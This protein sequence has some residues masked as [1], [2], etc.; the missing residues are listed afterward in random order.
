M[1]IIF[2][3]TPDFSVG[4]LEALIGAGHEIV[5]AVT[6]PDKPKGRGKSLQAPPVKEAALAHGIEVFQPR[7]IREGAE[8]GI[9]EE[10]PAGHHR[11]GGVWPDPSQG[12]LRD[13]A[14]W[15]C[16]RACVPAAEIPGRSPIQWA[17][18]EGEKVS[19][20]TTMRMDEGLDTGDMIMKEEVVL[21]PKETGGSLFEK[22]SRTGA[23][24][25][26]ENTGC[27]RSGNRGLYAAGSFPGDQ[28]GADPQTV[29]AD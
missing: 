18:I 13:A 27:H 16:E 23:A 3:G 24:L 25:W 21:D 4:T 1:R 14:L 26:C 17:V 9:S 19:G 5:L 2:M 28:S 15:L 22:L 11:G 10:I 20:V 7:R 12:D 8:R 6:Q 29:W